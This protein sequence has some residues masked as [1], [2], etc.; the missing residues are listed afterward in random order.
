M[1]KTKE[2]QNPWIDVAVDAWRRT[3]RKANS[4]PD[5]EGHETLGEAGAEES[6]RGPATQVDEPIG[7]QGGTDFYYCNFIVLSVDHSKG[8]RGV[9]MEGRGWREISSLPRQSLSQSWLFPFWENEG[10]V[11]QSALGRV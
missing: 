8:R 10:G 4:K 1:K 11:A 3:H 6:A 7:V 2:T 9:R 5:K